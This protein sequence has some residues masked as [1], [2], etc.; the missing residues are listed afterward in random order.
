MKIAYAFIL[1]AGILPTFAQEPSPPEASG[2]LPFP[3]IS[4]DPDAEECPSGTKY[5]GP[6][7]QQ[8]YYMCTDPE[9]PSDPLTHIPMKKGAACLAGYLGMQN[10]E[11]DGDGICVLSDPPK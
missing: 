8:C 2:E 11:C 7:Y 3:D 4:E 5:V 6:S 1:L 10:G 9:K